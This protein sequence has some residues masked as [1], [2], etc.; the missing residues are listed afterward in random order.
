MSSKR[1][2][3]ILL[4]SAFLFR[5]VPS[6]ALNP[7]I[8]INQYAQRVWNTRS[9]LPQSSVYNIAQTP[10]G[11]IWLGTEEGLARFDGLRFTIFDRV[12]G[13]SSQ[14]INGL[15]VG[16]DGSLW[17]A[18]DAG[19]ARWDGREFQEFR[20]PGGLS[21][22]YKIEMLFASDGALWLAT[23]GEGVRRF[24]NGKFE[25]LTTAQGLPD[26]RARGMAADS[27][28]SIWIATG[29]GLA[30]WRGG[31][32][33]VLTTQ[34]GL[35]SNTVTAVHRLRDGSLWVGTRFGAGVIDHGRVVPVRGAG[36]LRGR[37]I[38]GILDDRDGN[39]WVPTDD[40]LVRINSGGV[41]EYTK[42]DGLP[43]T[44]VLSM[45]EDSEGSLW[46]GM[47]DGGGIQLRDTRFINFGPRQGITDEITTSVLEAR[48]G[49][50]W[51]GTRALY[52]L[53]QNP[54]SVTVVPG[55]SGAYLT[56]LYEDGNG[57]I[58]AG[59]ERGIIFV[60]E[61]ARVT[62]TMKVSD[63]KVN[64]L[65]ADDSGVLWAATG[66]KGLFRLEKGAWVKPS[67]LG[68]PEMTDCTLH[69]ARGGGFWVTSRSSGL[70]RLRSGKVAEHFDAASGLASNHIMS[71]YEDA[72]GDL[73]IGSIVG[74]SRLRNG[75]ITNFTAAQASGSALFEV[76]E[77]RQGY[78][79]V[80][81]NLGV[82]RMSKQ[83]LN[84][85]ADGKRDAVLAP[86]LFGTADGLATPECNYY[87][88]PAS[89]RTR[90]GRMWFTSA[91]GLS[92]V[93]PDVKQ[94]ESPPPAVLIT[95]MTVNGR[96]A[97]AGQETFEPGA[98]SLEVEYTGITFRNPEFVR[99]QYQLEGFDRAWVD[100]GT[101]RVAYYT[102]LPPGR[103]RFR[104]K[105]ANRDGVWNE[106]GAAA[107]FYLKPHFQETSWF[108]GACVIVLGGA[109]VMAFRMRMREVMRRTDELELAIAART[110][111]LKSAMQAAEAAS[112][113][114]SEF[115]ANMS[116]EIRT[117]MNGVMGMTE[118]VLDTDLTPNQRECLE[119]ARHSGEA[120]LTVINDI[121]DFSKIEA[122]KLEIESIDFRL[123]KLVESSLRTVAIRAEQ[124]NLELISEVSSD[125]PDAL[126]GDPGRLRQVLLNLLGNAIKF[127]ET[128]E[129]TVTAQL[130]PQQ[131]GPQTRVLHFS[132]RDTGI[133]IPKE[134]QAAIFEAFSQ[135]DGSTTRKY[136]GTGLGLTICRKLVEM[137]GGRIW[138]E[139]EPGRGATMHFT[140]TFGLGAIVSNTGDY[141]MFDTRGKI[142]LIVDDNATN[143]R[144]L[145]GTLRAWGIASVSAASG[146]EALQVLQ[147]RRGEF[148]L[149]LLDGH[150]PEIDGFELA[151]RIQQRVLAPKARA[152]MLC[153]SSNA[154]DIARCKDAGIET[155]LTKPIRRADLWN[156]LGNL[157]RVA[158]PVST[159][160]AG[161]LG[162]LGRQVAGE[163]MPALRV[164]VAEDNVVNQHLISRLLARDGHTVVTAGDGAQAVEA[165]RVGN[166]DVILMD[167]Q[168]PQ[169]DGF[170]AT[171][172]IR[173]QDAASGRAR[174]PV[175]A[176][177]AHAMS[178]DRE[179]CL[180]AGMDDY[181]SKP[182]E[183]AQLRRVLAKVIAAPAAGPQAPIAS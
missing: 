95:D 131:A 165:H 128:G 61:N 46:L 85:F 59:D 166:F 31:K 97:Q 110:E 105:A 179:R 175:I 23:R 137:M 40:G 64:G 120:L 94:A 54:A 1:K 133:G 76:L 33:S 72:S 26:N 34:D 140:A 138:V 51:V 135:A 16:P 114:K 108:Y 13:L 69:A 142:A 136:G 86:T 151:R 29:N 183:V 141:P 147:D 134:K 63:S 60:V 87:G 17:I 177:T 109:V 43:D 104:V 90:D 155:Y 154:G 5:P 25:M 102:N 48:N 156:T 70:Y 89:I 119:M 21:S 121:L 6:Y 172:A 65:M 44:N 75:K 62:R 117:P 77:D 2:A 88:M 58:L 148:D 55:I 169:M 168:M 182:I 84:D 49:D 50:L 103:Y 38:Q 37:N 78:L 115:L 181:L 53:R 3:C 171:A 126:T 10:D 57:R 42:A 81:S 32:F 159:G 129:I 7:N 132:V 111:Q 170:E 22:A 8:A 158:E 28:G 153:S 113:A 106:A 93:A 92:A 66:G 101:R 164:L 52:R 68:F 82:L 30:N 56:A 100:A 118:L 157:L 127:T 9:G 149:I 162:A 176:L 161:S 96:R 180:E 174:I 130:D 15:A 124:K 160:P 27:D 35:P 24:K 91:S 67:G 146:A 36:I 98:G 19:L 150:M 18:L 74:L 122:G 79:W 73:W 45:L 125:I 71:A 178:R 139:S 47:I 99:F 163:P 11:Y 14:F 4:A 112:S 143:R 167:I 173:A 123:C 20:A 145:E 144:V 41:A 12:K 107:G 152:A 116:H 39:V 83:S 80:G